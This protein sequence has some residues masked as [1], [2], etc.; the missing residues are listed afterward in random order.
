[1]AKIKVQNTEA[2]FEKYVKTNFFES[3]NAK[4]SNGKKQGDLYTYEVTITDKTEKNTKT[5]KKTFVMRLNEG[6]DFVMSFSI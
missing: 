2:D 4:S 5:V 1:M 3:N 6:T